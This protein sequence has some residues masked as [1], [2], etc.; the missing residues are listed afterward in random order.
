M[1]CGGVLAALSRTRSLALR[2]AHQRSIRCPPVAASGGVR[3]SV[4]DVRAKIV[5][6]AR[7]PRGV[8]HPCSPRL[9]Q[10]R[11][12]LHSEFRLR[13]RHFEGLKPLPTPHITVS[14]LAYGLPRLA[15]ACHGL[16]RLGTACTALTFLTSRLGKCST[17][18]WC[19]TEP[20]S[21]IVEARLNF[22]MMPQ[23]A[24]VGI[25]SVVF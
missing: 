3:R 19:Q 12:V 23:P 5:E 10:S 9:A 22:I 11:S 17:T 7:Y 4:T 14:K 13:R 6:P 25:A 18:I 2:R 21:G 20:C 1:V 24:R 16:A 8:L 15:T